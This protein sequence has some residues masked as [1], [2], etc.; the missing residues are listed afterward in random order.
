MVDR[1][2]GG[3]RVAALEWLIAKGLAAQDPCP[4]N[5]VYRDPG[6]MPSAGGPKHDQEERQDLPS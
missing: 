5:G 2:F 3:D 1:H 6:P 4:W